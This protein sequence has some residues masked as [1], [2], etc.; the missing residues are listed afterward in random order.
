MKVALLFPARPELLAAL[1]AAAPGAELSLGAA[2]LD[3]ACAALREADAALGNHF[4]CEALAQ[5][6]HE[7][8]RFVQ[9]PSVGVERQLAALDGSSAVLCNAR[10]L[11]DDEL[12]DHA[13]A[14][15]L[16]VLRGLGGFRDAQRE[17]R[18]ERR[19]LQTLSG[20][21]ALVLGFGGVG[22]A[23]A[24]RLLAFSAEVVSVRRSDA[25]DFRAELPRARLLFLALPLTPLTRGII[26]ARELAL[27][28]DGAV[29]VNVARGELLDEDALLA[30]LRAG[31]LGAGLDVFA[32]EPL[33]AD[34]PLWSERRA[35]LTPHVARSEEREPHR[36]EPLFVENLRRF[37]SGQPLLN[38]VSR[39]H[40]Y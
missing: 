16:G 34:H 11:Y 36:W 13:L 35:L 18:W 38:Q 5:V 15:A 29:V 14:L 30:E 31:R 9:T 40:G 4:L 8:L 21:R 28:P 1:R 12:A 33:P 2:S 22:R 32:H 37:A 39:Q 7:R 10:G 19:P 25:V 27:L 24:R 3:A 6:P 17:R 23:I 26:G 20:A